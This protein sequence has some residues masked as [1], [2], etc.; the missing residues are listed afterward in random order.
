MASEYLTLL[1]TTITASP[2]P[3]LLFLF[4]L[5]LIFVPMKTEKAPHTP[6]GPWGVP[7]FGNLFQL[8]KAPHRKLTQY[9]KQYGDVYQIRMGSRPAVILNGIDVTWKALVKQADA[10]AGRPDFYT[11]QLMSD[12]KTMGMG[13]YGK[14]WKLHRKI[15]QNSLS[16]FVNNRDNPI[17]D[18][19]TAEANIL[20][21]HLL[22]EGRKPFNP[23]DEIYLSVGNIICAICFGK[24][25]KRDDPDFLRMVEM[26]D[27]FMAYAA[28]GNPVDILPW[29][30][31][32]LTRSLNNF[33][34]ILEVMSKFCLKKR[35]EHLATYRPDVTRD[36]TDILI[37]RVKETP[38]EE[39]EEAGLTD[40]HIL[41]TVQELIAAGFDTISSTLQWAL[42][43]LI[44]HPHVQERAHA[45]IR[46]Q[47][48]LRRAPCPEDMAHLPY[49][50]A[51]MLEVMRHSNIFPLALP[52]STTRDTVLQ[53]YHIPENTLVLVNLWSL[54]R[55]P[56]VFQDPERFLPERFL[57]SDGEEVNRDLAEKFLPYSA[58]RRRC[59][60]EQL[61]K[62]ELFI[63][64][65]V[66]VQRCRFTVPPEGPQPVVDSKYGLTLKPQ[67]F[68][69]KLLQ[70]C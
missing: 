25:Y 59:P 32:L 54:S 22:K 18:A 50:E 37:R 65:A 5:L 15:A 55:D 52:H 6:P 30:R 56:D 33:V 17:E 4:L 61:A 62:M 14:R 31:P 64:L 46:K 42:L 58:G 40:E 1:L 26:N 39:K 35:E 63:F 51:L 28:A 45:E 19:I 70:R 36:V 44:T 38:E 53:G 7:V 24:R 8:T 16:T 34:A 69:I 49:M 60:G 48:G 2:L 10:F 43:Y 41:N 57:D 3:Y 68:E 27:Q 23:H 20:V 47:V 13:N 66:M 9:R 67:D 12:G 21:S 29:T 11:F